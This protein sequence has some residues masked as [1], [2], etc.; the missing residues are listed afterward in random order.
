M[1]RRRLTLGVAVASVLMTVTGCAQIPTSG[2]VERGDEVQG[3]EDDPPVRVLPRGPVAGQSQQEVVE[4]FLDAS[5]SFEDR[6][7]VARRFLTTHAADQW[8]PDAGVTV[9]D[10]FPRPTYQ[11]QGSR[12][13][14]RAKQTARITREGAFVPRGGVGISR[15]FIMKREGDSWR[16]A[17]PP[18]GLLL[19]R[20][21]V[22]LAFRAYDVYFMNRASQPFLVADPV[23]LP[24]GQSGSATSLVQ[25]LLDGPTQWLRPAV[26]SMIPADTEL[27]LDSVPVENGIADVDLS[28]EFLN[29]DPEAQEQAAAQ[30]TATLLERSVSVTG[31]TISVEGTT[32]QLP[33][34]PAVF[35][36]ETWESFDPNALTPG[37]GA[38]FVREGVVR[39]LDDE[40]RQPKVQGA[41]GLGHYN[42]RDP[43]QSWDGAT[44]TALNQRR[45]QLLVTHPFLERR[46]D[47]RLPGR[48]LLPATIDANDRVW[49]LDVGGRRP[50]LWV[51]QGARWRRAVLRVPPGEITSLRVSADGTRMAI[52]VHRDSGRPGRGELMVGRVVPGA[53]RLRVEAFRRIERSLADVDD[54]SWVDGSTLV[55]LGSSSGSVVQPTLININR[56]VTD[57]PGELLVGL[58]SVVG[59]PGLPLLADT[60]RGVIWQSTASDWRALTPGTD[61][62]Y[63]G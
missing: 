9:I 25:A 41:L 14:L 61:P 16:I 58:T 31:V 12:V 17:K 36:S 30:I 39:R 44:I 38:L 40:G 45:T 43:S 60:P 63:P 53:D 37:L 54:A 2:P 22:S 7:A 6:H 34:A 50:T 5:A 15:T 48:G 24:V 35:T 8:N 33:S 59:A 27:Y 51:S 52:V 20:I 11:V 13:E 47:S 42:V 23:Y 26:E 55:V 1:M 10:D 57:V 19:D 32:L 21:E 49:A 4:G 29:A 56:T 3:T 62:A 46:V 18:P 28:A